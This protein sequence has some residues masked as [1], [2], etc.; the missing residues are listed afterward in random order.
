MSNDPVDV[1]DVTAVDANEPVLV[2]PRF[3]FPDRQRTKQLE[4]AV[5][6]I[7]VV[8]VGV[9]G[10]NVF[11]SD[12]LRRAVPLD[13]QMLGDTR[14]RLTGTAER[15]IG[16]PAELTLIIFA[17]DGLNRGT[18]APATCKLCAGSG[19]VFTEEDSPRVRSGTRTN[20]NMPDTQKA[21]TAT[22]IANR[23]VESAGALDVAGSGKSFIPAIAV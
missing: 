11:N 22:T 2:E 23:S 6:D 19:A 4:G 7:C 12:E 21:T 16:S 18:D 1:D 20:R 9:N 8:S 17:F 10:D 13:R 14:R 3:H 15:R 5:E